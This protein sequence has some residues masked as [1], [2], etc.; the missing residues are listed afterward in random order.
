MPAQLFDFNYHWVRFSCIPILHIYHH[1]I[2]FSILKHVSI[3]H[4]SKLRIAESFSIRLDSAVANPNLSLS[5]LS[6]HRHHTASGY[7]PRVPCRLTHLT[8]QPLPPSLP[9]PASPTMTETSAEG[10]S[11]SDAPITVHI[12]GF[13]VVI[14]LKHSC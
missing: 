10:S 14:G 12:K 13:F 7:L 9:P 6:R 8:P 5:R 2:T 1:L 4:I 3:A 11:K